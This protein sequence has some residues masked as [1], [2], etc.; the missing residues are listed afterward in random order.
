MTAASKSAGRIEP[1]GE[2]DAAARHR[3]RVHELE[4]LAA[5]EERP[6][7]LP[8]PP[9]ARSGGARRA[10]GRRS[11][12]PPAGAPDHVDGLAR[13][14]GE[15]GELVEVADDP[16]ASASSCR[17]A[18]GRAR[19]AGSRRRRARTPPRGGRA[20]GRAARRRRPGRR[21]WPPRTARTR[22]TCRRR[23]RRRRPAAAARG[24]RPRSRPSRPARR[25]RGWAVERH[26]HRGDQ[27]SVSAHA[28]PDGCNDPMVA[29]REAQPM[30]AIVAMLAPQPSGARHDQPESRHRRAA[31]AGLGDR[32]RG[33]ARRPLVQRRSRDRPAPRRRDAPDLAR[34]RRSTERRVETVEPPHTFAFRW[35]RREDTNREGSTLV[36]S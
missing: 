6:S 36:E 21:G 12:R 32:H 34:A 15:G 23:G 28:T 33:A 22:G 14:P 25:D 26:L 2:V 9:G 8:A 16:R 24:R 10:A 18:S 1:V 7:R 30:V 20:P 31:R 5:R 29:C 19:G 4:R 27:T 13:L 17:R 35:L 11:G 3:C